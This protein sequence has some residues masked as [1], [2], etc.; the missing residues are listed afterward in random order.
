MLVLCSGTAWT[1]GSA[2]QGLFDPEVF[3]NNVDVGSSLASLTRAIENPEEWERLSNRI[4]LLDGVAASLAVYVDEADEYY[5]E[6]E[7]I[8]GAWHG[9]E[10]VE[11]YRAWVVVD[12]PIFSGRL[13]ERAPRDPDPDLI[14]RNDRILVAVRILD[15]FTEPD[16]AVVPVLGAFDIRKMR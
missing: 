8:T 10:R 16:G 11:V 12:D 2:L 13:A 14:L 4:L 3:R 7:L 9:V 15:L 1:Q 6:I 5:A